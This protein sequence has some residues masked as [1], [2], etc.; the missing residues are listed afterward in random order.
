MLTTPE[1][2]LSGTLKVIQT[3]IAKWKTKSWSSWSLCLELNI[4]GIKRSKWMNFYCANI[5]TKIMLTLC[6]HVKIKKILKSWQLK[7]VKI[8][9]KKLSSFLAFFLNSDILNRT[10]IFESKCQIKWEIV[11]NFVPFF[12]GLVSRLEIISR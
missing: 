10:Q 3:T 7:C 5:T 1:C 11:S 2:I 9:K 8:V 12:K 4:R 6:H